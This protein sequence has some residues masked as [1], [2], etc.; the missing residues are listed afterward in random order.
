MADWHELKIWGASDDLIEI[1]GDFSE[2]IDF[3]SRDDEF[4]WLSVSDGTLLKVR[5]DGFWRITVEA[6]GNAAYE[7]REATDEEHDYSDIITLRSV[8]PFK[9]VMLGQRLVK[10][11]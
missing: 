8:L 2:E 6:K 10:A 11:K 5:Y 1:G 7:K 4:A 9:Y 3:Y